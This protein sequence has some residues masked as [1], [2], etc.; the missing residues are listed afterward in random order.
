[1]NRRWDKSK[2]ILTRTRSIVFLLGGAGFPLGIP[3]M[4]ATTYLQNTSC[5][6]FLLSDDW[7]SMLQPHPYGKIYLWQR[8][9]SL[10]VTS[11]TGASTKPLLSTG[12]QLIITAKISLALT[13]YL[14]WTLG[15]LRCVAAANTERDTWRSSRRLTSGALQARARVQWRSSLWECQRIRLKHS[16]VDLDG[17]VDMARI[18]S[19]APATC[20]NLTKATPCSHH[21][22]LDGMV[23]IS[24]ISSEAY[25]L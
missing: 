6:P 23:A 16:L 25:Y 19:R 11:R 17:C 1:V 7:F 12:Q 5:G 20:D 2:K 4:T 10:P 21:T 22:T 24:Q 9:I 3:Y 15:C 13:H 8:H 14:D 18:I